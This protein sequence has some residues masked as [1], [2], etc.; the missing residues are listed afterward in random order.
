LLITLKRD[1]FG[2]VVRLTA[3]VVISVIGIAAVVADVQAKL[4]WREKESDK[5]SQKQHTGGKQANFSFTHLFIL[6]FLLI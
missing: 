3:G 2:T 4:Y 5:D 1:I 6:L